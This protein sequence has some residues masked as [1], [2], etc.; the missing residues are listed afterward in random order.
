MK[1]KYLLVGDTKGRTVVDP[2]TEEPQLSGLYLWSRAFQKYSGKGS[3]ELFWRKEDLEDYDIVH[4]NYTPSNIQLPGVIRDQLGDSSSTK[5]V[6]NVDLDTHYWGVN[7]GHNINDFIREL[8]L[9]DYLFHV[10]SK[11][12]ESLEMLLNREIHINPHPVDVSGIYDYMLKEREPVIGTIFHRYFPNTVVPFL[13]QREIPLRRVLFGYVPV[14]KQSVVANA[15]MYDQIVPLQGFKKHLQEVAKCAIG[16]DLYEGHTYGR[17]IVEL[18]ALGIPTVCSS[19]IEAG[20]R[21]FPQTTVGPYDI[22]E[23]RQRLTLLHED[24]E[25]ANSVIIEANKACSY[26]S[27]ENSYKRFVEMIE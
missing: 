26:Y 14:G 23:A 15:G 18:A 7:F 3:I 27:L 8:K 21:L 25:F 9:A 10:E 24:Q 4:V 22:H 2:Q 16:C 13:V 17:T 6:I 20:H 12:A 19:T 11:G 1:Y 5:L